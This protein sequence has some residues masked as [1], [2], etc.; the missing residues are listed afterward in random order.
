MPVTEFEGEKTRLTK[1]TPALE[2]YSQH[3]RPEEENEEDQADFLIFD[4][5]LDCGVQ[6]VGPREGIDLWN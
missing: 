3:D 6:Q 5:D 2:K 1:L 4:I